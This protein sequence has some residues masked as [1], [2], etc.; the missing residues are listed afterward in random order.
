MMHLDGILELLRD[1]RW[2]SIEEIKKE[3]TIP[4][5]KLNQILLFLQ[6]QYLICKE[7]EKV[8]ITP[9]GLKFLELPS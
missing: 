9:K 1:I 4:D 2:H 5:E 3:T 6:E 7:N 8:K